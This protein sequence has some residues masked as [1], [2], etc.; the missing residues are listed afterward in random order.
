MLVDLVLAVGMARLALGDLDPPRRRPAPG[1]GSRRRPG[2]RGPP[3]RRACST[4]SALIGQQLKRRSWAMPSL[5][6]EIEAAAVLA[7]ELAA[8]WGPDGADDK[9]GQDARPCPARHRARDRGRRAGGTPPRTAGSASST[10]TPG[11][12]RSRRCCPRPITTKSSAGTPRASWG[13]FTSTCRSEDP[14]AHPRN[15][16]RAELT[17][18]NRPRRR[19]SR[20][21]CPGPWRDA[22][23]AAGVAGAA[24]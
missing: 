3:R 19:R 8:E 12:R 9:R 4:F 23:R 20:R 18:E 5:R 10:R 21:A 1:P 16:R 15:A 24:R 11:C 2:R 13:K 7:A 6:D 22:R 14:S 17:G